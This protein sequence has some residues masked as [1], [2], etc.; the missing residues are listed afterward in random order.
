MFPASQHPPA[1]TE[2]SDL[3][4]ETVAQML[5]AES[6]YAALRKLQCEVTE[7][8]VIV[9]GFLPSYYLKQKAQSIL[10][11]LDRKRALLNLVDVRDRKGS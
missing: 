7:T 5:L 10:R 11:R 4:L 9:R 6:G 1:V 2:W 8:L 3:D